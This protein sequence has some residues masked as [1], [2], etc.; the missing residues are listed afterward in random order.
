MARKYI[1]TLMAANRVGILSAVTTAMTELGGDLQEVSQTVMQKF[2]TIIMAAEFPDHRDPQVIVE[3]IRG[4][5]RPFGIEVSLKDPAQEPETAGSGTIEK[6][7]LT[8]VGE[9]RPGMIRQ[10]SARLAQDG[11]DITDL[12]AKRGDDRSF[13]M[14]MEL[15]VPS[16]VDTLKLQRELE[17]LGSSVGLSAALQH[18]D[19]FVA[20]N[21]P[22][23]VRVRSRLRRIDAASALEPS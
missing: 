13:V 9:D 3:H 2:F 23:P 16:G 15:A 12:Y 14:I 10:I 21:D 1:I 18:E 17:D 4:F 19:I 6:Y 5:C 22:R 11:I 8:A 20:T 7:F